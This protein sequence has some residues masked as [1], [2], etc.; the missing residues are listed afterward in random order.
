MFGVSFSLQ[1]RILAPQTE[2][3]ATHTIN[4]FGEVLEQHS[5]MISAVV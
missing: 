2:Q 4:I 5:R 1:A 3:L